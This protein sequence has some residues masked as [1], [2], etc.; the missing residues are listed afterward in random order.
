M[1]TVPM[2]SE[3]VHFQDLCLQLLTTYLSL[4]NQDED[5][6]IETQERGG[7]SNDKEE[8]KDKTSK[9]EKKQLMKRLMDHHPNQP[10]PMVADIVPDHLPDPLRT[11]AADIHADQISN[12]YD[13]D[14]GVA[15][16]AEGSL[17]TLDLITLHLRS[18]RNILD[19][20][21]SDIP[22]LRN[23]FIRFFNGVFTELLDKL[24]ANRQD[25]SV[26]R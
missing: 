7:G 3:Y 24:F 19:L 10:Q 20:Q 6:S 26:V 14:Q 17:S 13:I 16:V 1:A 25:S 23:R 15:Q 22:A 2:E 4:S 12:L 8:T 5:Y 11:N 9:N 18:Y 21:L